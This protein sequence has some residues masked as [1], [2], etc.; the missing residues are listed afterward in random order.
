MVDEQTR[1]EALRRAWSGVGETYNPFII[2]A[3]RTNTL[4]GLALSAAVILATTIG[5]A[6]VTQQAVLA[7]SM[8]WTVLGGMGVVIGVAWLF[9]HAMLAAAVYGGAHE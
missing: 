4:V 8:L 9:Q 2:V 5:I 3:K 6:L 7:S 1:I